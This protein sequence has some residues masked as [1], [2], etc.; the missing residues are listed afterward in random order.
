MPTPLVRQ[1]IEHRIAELQ[2]QIAALHAELRPTP[3]RDNAPDAEP[4]QAK[5]RGQAMT[6]AQRTAI[7]RRMKRYWRERRQQG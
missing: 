7:S 1:L 6:A 3:V 2:D 4:M 5:R